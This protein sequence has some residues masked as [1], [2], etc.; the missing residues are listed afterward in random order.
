MLHADTGRTVE[1]VI[2]CFECDSI[3]DYSFEPKKTSRL[4]MESNIMEAA[5]DGWDAIGHRTLIQMQPESPEFLIRSEGIVGFVEISFTKE[6]LDQEA[7][8]RCSEEVKEL[9]QT[10]F[11]KA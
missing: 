8:F 3:L 9:Y 1:S 7:P 6:L 2:Q 4:V 10:G 5:L 11:I